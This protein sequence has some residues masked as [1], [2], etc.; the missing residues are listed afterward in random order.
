MVQMRN[1]GLVKHVSLGMNKADFLL[2]YVKMYP[3]GTFDSILVAGCWNLLDQSGTEL[4]RECQN[5]GIKV[6]LGGIFG[7][8]LLWGVNFL[9]Y[10]PASQE[11]VERRDK[12]A[13]LAAKH[14]CSLPAVALNFAFLPT[15][16]SELCL[17]C[18]T[19]EHVETNL[20]LLEEKV[21]A[22]LWEEAKD[23]G[24]LPHWF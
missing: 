11:D 16:V 5:R 12:W 1:E 8:G 21:P 2:A 22:A 7:S 14:G 24:M 23:A 4:L 10:A 6:V 18:Q 19:P 9:R 20:A 17:G 15:C 3:A 13:A